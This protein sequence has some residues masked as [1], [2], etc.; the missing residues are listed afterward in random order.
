[1]YMSKKAKGSIKDCQT[2]KCASSSSII[3]EDE[4]RVESLDIKDLLKHQNYQ[5]KPNMSKFLKSYVDAVTL[6]ISEGKADMWPKV[7]YSASKCI[8]RFK[9]G[10]TLIKC[11]YT[12]PS[13]VFL[14]CKYD[15]VSLSE[16]TEAKALEFFKL[17]EDFNFI[18]LCR[19]S[20]G[21]GVFAPNLAAVNNELEMETTCS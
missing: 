11:Y 13:Q 9:D 8:V 16:S 3:A 4:K 18:R 12:S 19:E 17:L 15:E 2:S 1:M 14:F 7:H 6:L 21:T 5:T 10:S 20:T